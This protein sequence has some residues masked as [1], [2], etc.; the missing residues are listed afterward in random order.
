MKKI[1]IKIF[2]FFLLFSNLFVSYKLYRSSILQSVILNDYNNRTFSITPDIFDKFDV[3]FPNI[4][5]TTVPIKVFQGRYFK[6][7][8]SINEAIQLFK[9]SIEI[10]PYMMMAEGELSLAYYDLEEYDSAYHYGKKAFYTLPNN[11]T[12]RFAYFQA[13][14]YRKDSVGLDN[15][16]EL[17]KD[18]NNTS[19]WINYL[20]SRNS[21]SQKHTKYADSILKVYKKNFN[22]ENDY[23][24]RAF[25]SRIV[26]GKYV[27]VD[28][29][30]ISEDA[31]SFYNEKKFLEAGELYE[32]ALSIDSY[33]YT[34]FP[35]EALAYA[36]TEEVDKAISYFDKVIYDFKVKDGKS[37]FYKGI[38]LLKIE[39]KDQGCKY[40]K[41]AAEF[42]FS[43]QGSKDMYLSLC[44]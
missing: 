17:I 9:E 44:L 18:K 10:N 43:G 22:L 6:H 37:H 2:I 40:L 5:Q 12:H 14:V 26:N 13:L 21:I 7:N 23:I 25:E 41:Q 34:Y 16:F 24:A 32:L 39:K 35:N 20:L 11:N 42:Q 27:V 28:A 33:D 29:V 3:S 4:T 8:S 19:H 15:A 30:K 36:N 1:V 31:A 38:L